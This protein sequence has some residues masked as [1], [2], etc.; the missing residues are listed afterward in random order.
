[1]IKKFGILAL[2]AGILMMLLT[3]LALVLDIKADTDYA[4]VIKQENFDMQ[5]TPVAG[6]LLIITGVIVLVTRKQKVLS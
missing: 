4:G 1:M 2:T 3:K 6:A 5:E